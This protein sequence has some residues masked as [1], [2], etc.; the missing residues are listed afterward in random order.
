[1]RLAF[2]S[3]TH[4]GDEMCTLVDHDTLAKGPKWDDFAEASGTQNDF[5][6]LLG[7]IFD[8]SIASYEDAYRHARA[9]FKFVK[10][11][12]IAKNIIYQVRQGTQ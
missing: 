8:L 1:M 5:L 6:V 12:R 10:R 3:D 9:F 7:D 11:H 2:I 4:F